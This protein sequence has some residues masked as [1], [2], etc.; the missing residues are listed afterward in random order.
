VD[1]VFPVFI[2]ESNPVLNRLSND[3]SFIFLFN[4]EGSQKIQ[5]FFL[6]I[7]CMV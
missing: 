2:P 5:N 3:I 4:L 1:E 6:R 7:R